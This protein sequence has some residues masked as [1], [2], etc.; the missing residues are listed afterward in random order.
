MQVRIALEGLTAANV[1]INGTAEDLRS[2]KVLLEQ[3]KASLNDRTKFST[4][5]LEFHIALAKASGNSLAMD[6]ISMIRGQ[7]ARTLN[8]V[9]VL[10]NARP[11]SLDEHLRIVGRI[12]DRDAEGARKAMDIHLNAALERYR[13]RIAIDNTSN[14]SGT[15][16]KTTVDKATRPKKRSTKRKAA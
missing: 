2:L 11:L 7:L 12:R 16:S 6:L 15:T 10:P 9:L 14:E 8:R 4:L 13:K 3:M 1:A 5:D